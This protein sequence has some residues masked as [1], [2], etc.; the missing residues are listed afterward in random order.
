M[1]TAYARRYFEPEF[2][3]T[4]TMRAAVRLVVCH[5]AGKEPGGLQSHLNAAKRDAQ[6]A[7]NTEYL[8]SRYGKFIHSWGPGKPHPKLRRSPKHRVQPLPADQL[9]GS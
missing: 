5:Y 9:Y 2:E 8:M 7:A 4:S 1:R 6:A 3:A